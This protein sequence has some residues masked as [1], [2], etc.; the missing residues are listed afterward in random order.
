MEWLLGLIPG[1]LAGLLGGWLWGRSRL[2]VKLAESTARLESERQGW[3]NERAL[4]NEQLRQFSAG[5]DEAA[6]AKFE[7]LK[8]EFR[9]LAEKLLNEKSGELRSANKEQLDAILTPLKER[10]G[11]FRKSIDLQHA[12]NLE[13]NAGLREQLRLMTETARRVGAEADHLARALKGDSK[14]QGNWGEMIL[15]ELLSSSGLRENIHYFKQATLTD[16][17]GQAVRNDDNDRVMRPDVT[18]RYPDGKVVIIDSKVSLSAYVDYMN[19]EDQ[20]ARDEALARHLRSVRAHVEELVRKNY[21]AHVRKSHQEAVDF[22]VMFIPNEAPYQLAMQQAPTLWR[23]AFERGVLMISPVNLMALL[24]LIHLSWKRFDQERNQR[25]ILD[26]A[27]QL[28]DRI[29]SFY[30]EFDEVGKKL[31]SACDAYRKSVDRLRGADGKRS[32]VQKAEQLKQLGVRMKK[33][34]TLPARLQSAA[35]P[36]TDSPLLPDDPD[37][38]TAGN[39][40]EN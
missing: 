2:A 27:A 3:E 37:G 38:E 18:I 34:G 36:G 23:E 20:A 32:V 4:L 40:A 35:V 1:L 31:E 22:V 15:D 28:L 33:A 25:L 30:A 5:R 14:L 29:Y 11:E 19:A 6:A 17:D 10:I 26:N 21:A 16:D 13:I 9:N 8:A 39:P 7:L 12:K 24:Q